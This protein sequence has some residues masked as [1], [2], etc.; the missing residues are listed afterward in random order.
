MNYSVGIDIGASTTKA[1]ILDHRGKVLG[2]CVTGSG[3]DFKAAADLAFDKAQKAA[4]VHV[5]RD[6]R[7]T[8][9]GYG[10]KNVPYADGTVTEI[11]CHARGS[12]HYFPREHTVVDIGGQD[13]KIIK[14]AGS[15][16]RLGFRMNRKCAAGTGAFLEEIANRLEIE[17]PELNRLAERAE[18]EVQIGSYCTVFAAS[19]IL[20]KIREGA[21]VPDIVKGVFFS[22][23]KRVVEMAPL[24]GE[25]A[26]SGGVVAH[27]PFLVGVFEEHLGRKML[28]PPLP[29]LTGA[30]GAALYHTQAIG[31]H[32]A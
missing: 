31:G 29:Q 30:F 1:I 14:V 4:G 15:G 19:E 6:C 20:S 11:S 16:K 3:A 22:V 26:L 25:V 12:Y 7:I 2:H 9:T 28:V 8:T 27:F 18:R 17:L 24:E 5:A 23:F 10:R 13:S 32:D 21:G